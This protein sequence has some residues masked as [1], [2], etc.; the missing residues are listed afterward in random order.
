MLST[1][2]K[3]SDRKRLYTTKTFGLGRVWQKSTESMRLHIMRTRRD[4][5]LF[6]ATMKIQDRPYLLE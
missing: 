2:D 6:R 5:R 1:E 3:L 4:F